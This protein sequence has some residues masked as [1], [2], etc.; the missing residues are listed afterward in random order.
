VRAAFD[1]FCIEVEASDVVV[2]DLNLKNIVYAVGPEGDARF[3]LIDGTG[4]D[5]LIPV[6]RM[7]K[8]L[9]RIVKKRKIAGTR[10]TLDRL[11]A[12]AEADGEKSPGN[13]ATFGSSPAA[14]PPRF[15]TTPTKM[16][17]R[18]FIA[19]AAGSLA[20]DETIAGVATLLV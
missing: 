9:N 14:R 5:T 7:S 1:R 10:R 19:C 13:A 16:A 8:T 4:D 11:V 20:A 15:G 3:V 17:A 12:A 18:S 6:L 2:S